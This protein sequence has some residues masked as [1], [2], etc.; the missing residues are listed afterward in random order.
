M[1]ILKYIQTQASGFFSS[2][3]FQSPF[4]IRHP[5]VYFKNKRP[6][7][8]ARMLMDH[9]RAVVSFFE[10]SVNRLFL[11]FIPIKLLS[12]APQRFNSRFQKS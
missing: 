5:E 1:I 11:G 10:A 9:L 7:L 6:N 8:S 2:L 3:S 4:R 12:H